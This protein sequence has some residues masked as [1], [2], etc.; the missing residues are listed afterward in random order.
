MS[1]NSIVFGIGAYMHF[2]DENA[3]ESL[4]EVT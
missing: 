3:M 2:L 4:D 1:W